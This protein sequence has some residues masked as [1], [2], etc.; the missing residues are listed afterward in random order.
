MGE[1]TNKDLMDNFVTFMASIF[2]S[3]RFGGASDAHG[4]ANMIRFYYFQEKGAFERDAATG[5]YRVNFDKMQEAM[6]S[7]SEL[8]LKIQGDGDYAATGKLIEKEVSIREEL[9]KYLDRI[10]AAGFHVTLFLNRELKLLA[11]S[12]LNKYQ[13]ML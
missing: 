1:F 2:R 8:I 9:Q 12:L 6:I 7:L 13:N 5:M 3:V 4:K 11:Y 10:E